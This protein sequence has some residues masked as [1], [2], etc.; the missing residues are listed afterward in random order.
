M[1]APT[2]RQ[3]G[4]SDKTRKAVPPGPHTLTLLIADGPH[5]TIRLPAAADGLLARTNL[6]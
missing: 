4:S 1:H 3:P 6:S 5:V 2:P